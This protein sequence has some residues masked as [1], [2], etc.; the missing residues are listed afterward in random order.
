MVARNNEEWHLYRI[1]DDE[2]ELND[3]SGEFP[4]KKKEMEEKWQNWALNHQ[5]LPKPN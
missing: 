5:V 4:E 3:L 1:N 2:T